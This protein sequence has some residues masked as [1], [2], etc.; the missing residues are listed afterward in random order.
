MQAYRATIESFFNTKA[1]LL[2]ETPAFLKA[3]VAD[4]LFGYETTNNTNTSIG[5]EAHSNLQQ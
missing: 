5:Q 4:H 2:D 3:S 1:P